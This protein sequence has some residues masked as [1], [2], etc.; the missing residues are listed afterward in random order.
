MIPLQYEP[1]DSCPKCGA[2]RKPG[3]AICWL[4]CAALP[5]PGTGGAVFEDAAA[6]WEPP[7]LDPPA[8]SFQFGLSSLFLLMTLAAILC[9]V[10]KM[11]PGLG[12][13]MAILS[14]PALVWTMVAASRRRSR[15][16]PMSPGRKA[17]MFIVALLAVVGAVVAVVGAFVVAFLATCA[18]TRTGAGQ[19]DFGDPVAALVIGG[20]AAFG[21]VLFLCILFRKVTRRNR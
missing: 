10:I 13:A 21:V 12:I 11:N 3:R 16:N 5:R 6:I 18:T 17:G 14:T 2:V 7:R 20:I 15:G 1:A 19:Y 4:Y 8:G 9:S